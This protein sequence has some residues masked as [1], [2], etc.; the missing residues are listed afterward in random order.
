MSAFT[1]LEITEDDYALAQVWS[2]AHGNPVIKSEWLP[3]TGFTIYRDWEPVLMFWM[4]FDN[5][6]PVTFIDWVISRP[7]STASETRAALFYAM[8]KPIPKA[9]IIHGAERALTRSPAA[10]VRDMVKH[11]WRI[12]QKELCS[13]VY[14]LREEEVFAN[15]EF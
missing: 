2:G 11:G 6:C 3:T 4:Y 8:D 1:Y 9:M 15:E 10:F 13:M 5:S 7:G 14:E 12:Y